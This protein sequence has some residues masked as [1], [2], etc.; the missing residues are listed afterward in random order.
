MKQSPRQWYKRFDAY[1]LKICFKRGDFDTCLYYNNIK[2]G[3][4]V[5]LLLY[6]DDLLLARPNKSQITRLSKF[7][8]IDLGSARKILGMV[9]NRNVPENKLTIT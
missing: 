9:I 4:E 5:Y 8:M 6:I 7:D 3:C 2:S 1:V